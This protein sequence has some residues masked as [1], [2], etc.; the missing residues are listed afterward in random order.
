MKISIIRKTEEWVVNEY[1]LKIVLPS[2]A[3]WWTKTNQ[4]FSL[5]RER[6]KIIFVLH[7]ATGAEAEEGV[8]LLFL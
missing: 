5:C 1:E 7:H 8:C 3:N 6:V 4:K 2:S